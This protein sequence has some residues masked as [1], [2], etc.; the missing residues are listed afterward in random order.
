MSGTKLQPRQLWAATTTSSAASYCSPFTLPSNG[1]LVVNDS[2]AI[3]LTRDAVFEPQCTGGSSGVMHGISDNATVDDFRDPFYT[4]ISP[5]I[6]ALAAASVVSYVL[7]IMLFITPRTFFV[8]GPGGGSGFLSRRGFISGSYGNSAVTG[9]GRR[10]WLQ[11]IAAVSVAISL[12]IATAD[13]FKVAQRQYNLGYSDSSAMMDEVTTSLEIRIVRV[14]SDTFLWL[15]QVQTLIRLFPRH[16]EK[17]VIKWL[18]FALIVTDTLFSIL[19]NF[20][21]Y[22][23]RT[24]PRSFR[25]AISALSYLFELAIGLIYASCIIYF[26]IA[27]RRY[28]YFHPKM[29]NICIVALLSILSVLIP[30]VF[31]VL[32]ITKPDVAGWGDYIRWVGAAAA[33]VVVWEW[34]ERIEALE[35]DERKDGIL[36]REI[37][38]GDEMLEVT[39]SEEVDRPDQSSDGSDIGKGHSAPQRRRQLRPRVPFQDR[40]SNGRNALPLTRQ[41]AHGGNKNQQ[42]QPMPPPA[43]ITPVSRAETT[44]VASTQY[45][46]HCHTIGSPSPPIPELP[47]VS[48]P[49]ATASTDATSDTSSVDA[50]KASVNIEV[51]KTQTQAWADVGYNM[52]RSIPNPFKRRKASPP[53]EVASAMREQRQDEPTPPAASAGGKGWALMSKLDAFAQAQRDRLRSHLEGTSIDTTLPVTVI[54]AQPRGQRTWSPEEFDHANPGSKQLSQ[55]RDGEQSSILPAT[56]LPPLGTQSRSGGSA[57]LGNATPMN[58]DGIANSVSR[59][60]HLTFSED[61]TRTVSPSRIT[62][63]NNS[64]HSSYARS[65]SVSRGPTATSEAFEN[66]SPDVSNGRFSPA[67][68][69]VVPSYTMARAPP[70]SA[71]NE[72]AQSLGQS[73][74]GN[75]TG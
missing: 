18:G 66:H 42:I 10:P 8:G 1:V 25:D 55:G 35:R 44:S 33:S 6:Y 53:A 28:A 67:D 22:T 46:V 7:V 45:A 69:P 54:P 13:T 40:C 75:I 72:S 47:I 49:P 24:R 14:I 39:P 52:L 48:N 57:T 19:N 4:S 64:R 5:Q 65:R 50:E 56:V 41:P 21:Y 31:F 36:G 61:E 11:K 58:P 3:T 17:V 16:K 74:N 23:E 59:R 26:S 12:T 9:V 30:V 37:F 63:G 20:V 51:P 60:G 38:D 2:F 15:A 73:N 34:V 62:G 27:K 43:T 71:R 68:A 29:R 70:E 32:D